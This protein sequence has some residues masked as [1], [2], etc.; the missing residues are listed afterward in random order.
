MFYF[1]NFILFFFFLPLFLL[2]FLLSHVPD[3]VLV[4]RPGVR[5]EPWRWES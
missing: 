3:M 1:N 2:P 4:L 5:P